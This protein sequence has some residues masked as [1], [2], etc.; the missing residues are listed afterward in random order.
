[1]RARTICLSISA[2][3][4]WCLNYQ[5]V[6]QSRQ[7]RDTVEGINSALI[8]RDEKL[9]KEDL[10]HGAIQVAAMLKDRPRMSECIKGNTAILSWTVRQFAGFETGYRIFW[11]DSAPVGP[12]PAENCYAGA[13]ELPFIRVDNVDE[14][15]NELDGQM[16]WVAAIYELHNIRNGP[17]FLRAQ[18]DKLS[19]SL[20]KKKWTDTNARLEYNAALATRDFFLSVWEPE[21]RRCNLP[22]TPYYWRQGLPNSYERWI[23][24]KDATPFLSYWS[25]VY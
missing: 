15:R 10:R 3:I 18:K 24:T 7:E 13:G 1:M 21:S 17:A 12:G 11:S 9:S 4:V 5:L 2:I 22:S 6:T 20:D 8:L 25:S 19:G 14:Q 16:Q 23:K